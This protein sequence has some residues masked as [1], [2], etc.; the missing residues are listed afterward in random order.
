M[1]PR[2]ASMK[3]LWAGGAFP[4]TRLCGWAVI[5]T[6]RLSFGSICNLITNWIRPG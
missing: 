3:L 5:S 4:P 6:P 2:A 1:Y